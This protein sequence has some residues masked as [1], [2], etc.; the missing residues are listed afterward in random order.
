MHQFDFYIALAKN[1]DRR[2]REWAAGVSKRSSYDSERL[3]VQ[4]FLGLY[5]ITEWTDFDSIVI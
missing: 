3:D 2:P 1:D 4:L 5:L